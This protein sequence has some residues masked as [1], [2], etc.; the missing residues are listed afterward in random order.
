MGFA[1]RRRA[2]GLGP[3]ATAGFDSRRA[4]S[5]CGATAAAD[6]PAI[7]GTA[8]QWD[9]SGSPFEVVVDSLVSS[10]LKVLAG[11]TV[12]VS[13]Q[14]TL[15][16]RGEIRIEG[17]ASSPVVF[18]GAS[19]GGSG[20]GGSG[21][22]YSSSQALLSMS[23]TNLDKS[24]IKHAHFKNADDCIRLNGDTSQHNP[25]DKNSGTMIVTMSLFENCNIRTRG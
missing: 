9:V 18:Q 24:F 15:T 22:D 19:D 13:P 4:L 8:T 2:C 6:V 17:T 14:K 12:T 5:L 10:T 25:G 7:I 1:P 11:S 3:R 20:D 23:K 16:V 21:D